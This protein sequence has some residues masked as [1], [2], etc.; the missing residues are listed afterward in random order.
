V[1]KRVVVPIGHD[2]DG[3]QAIPVAA[4]LADRAQVPVELVTVVEPVE[5]LNARATLHELV[6]G[7]KGF[8]A[9][10]IDTG[11]PPEPALLAELHGGEPSLWC[12]G[13][14]VRGALTEV[15]F[16]SLSEEFVRHAHAPVVLVGPH[17]E[18]PLDGDG[19]ALALDGTARSESLLPDASDLANR[20]GMNLR[21]VQ[22]APERS[23]V[24]PSDISET[25]YLARVA[26]RLTPGD[27]DYEVV[28][29]RGVARGLTD[30]ASR[31]PN[32]GM[33]AVS[34]RGLKGGAR[35]LHGST[36]FDVARMAAVPV[37]ILHSV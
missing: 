23:G 36:A 9:R 10:V 28:Y 37:L 21:L 26:R 8:T 25:S 27:V 22:V 34:S 5:K 17:V 31:E 35:I 24:F 20:L 7:R 18:G 32:V 33:L 30:Y 12:V 3:E 2:H 19:I 11:G 14:H 29:A 16:G 15:V 6:K 13:S 1:F 4:A